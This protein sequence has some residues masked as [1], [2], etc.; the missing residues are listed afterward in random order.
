MIVIKNVIRSGDYMGAR[1]WKWIDWSLFSLHL[2]WYLSISV[3]LLANSNRIIE[4]FNGIH[5]LIFTLSYVVPQFFWRPNYKNVVGFTLAVLLFGGFV[6][7]LLY[8]WTDHYIDNMSVPMILLGYL[9]TRKVAYWSAPIAILGF[10][11]L[12]VMFGHQTWE[13]TMDTVMNHL[14]LYGI[15]VGYNVFIMNNR[16]MKA[17]LD[18]NKKQYQLI[19]QYATQV[20]A[21]T[22]KE[23]RNRLAGEL[24][25]TVGYA[26]TSLIMGLEASKAL[27]EMDP[28]KAGEKMEGILQQ[29]RVSVDHIRQQIHQI[30]PTEE[31]TM[32]SMHFIDEIRGFS[33]YSDIQISFKLIGQE[34]QV[35]LAIQHVLTRCLQETLTN[36]VRHGQARVIIVTL[37]YEAD[38]LILIVRDDGCGNHDLTFGFGLSTM[39]QR[40]TTVMGGLQINSGMNAGTEIICTVPI[41]DQ[42]GNNEIRLVIIDDQDLIRESLQ[43]VFM[44]ESDL[45]VVGLGQNGR[46]AVELCQQLNPNI[47]LLDV[48]MLEMNG[49]EATRIIKQQWP[50]IKIIILTTFEEMGSAKEAISLGAEGYLLKTIH[51]RDLLSAIRLVYRGGTLMSTEVA[52]QLINLINHSNDVPSENTR[53]TKTHEYDLTERELQVLKYLSDGDKYRD[54]AQKLFLSEGTVRNYVSSLYSK[55]E[56]NNRT[57]A[58]K[59]AQMHGLVRE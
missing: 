40:L 9:A 11:L 58:M 38:Q 7:G 37:T 59:K 56:V 48:Q 25:D 36:A 8:Y 29:A 57:Q 33:D 50:H 42:L 17:L 1:R 27:M 3:Y 44:R 16:T 28:N 14:L 21:L 2:F 31:N 26:F 23:E 22:L 49:V 4:G 10:P 12:G 19:Q 30:K 43:I 46:E 51:P 52:R 35:P 24:H 45:E 5:F 13:S 34:I 20:E 54:I 47:I 18:K 53:L 41:K 55:L 15:G 6:T 39:Q 32:L